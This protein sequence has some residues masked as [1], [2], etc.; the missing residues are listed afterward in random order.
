[1]EPNEVEEEQ[2]VSMSGD[3][4]P[5]DEE[6]GDEGSGD[7]GESSVI[8]VEEEDQ[9]KPE[10]ALIELGEDYSEPE[11]EESGVE[12]YSESESESESEESE[13]SESGEAEECGSEASGDP[14][15]EAA[16]DPDPEIKCDE[17]YVFKDANVNLRAENLQFW[18]HEH[19]LEGFARL[20]SKLDRIVWDEEEEWKV[21]TL[22]DSA[23]DV[24][25][26]LAVLYSKPYES[27]DFDSH[28]WESTL[29][30]AT[31]Y[32]HADIRTYAIKQLEGLTLDPI[33]RFRIARDYNVSGWRTKALDNLASRDEPIAAW[34]AEILG[35]E[36]FSKVAA[37]REKIQ[38]GRGQR[39]AANQGGKR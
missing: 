17:D 32:D 34:E 13:D 20:K 33:D 4:E 16:E 25:N 15:S 14:E 35:S 36:A 11:A 12:S 5:G 38:Y 7:D 9:S 1:M 22:E 10:K 8:V 19:M 28:T 23:E 24:Q 27:L 21:I 3:E 39:A 30:L 26:M 31:K 18:L 29:K 37:K 2:D 6:S